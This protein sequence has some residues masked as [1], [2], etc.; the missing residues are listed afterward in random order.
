MRED[1]NEEDREEKQEGRRQFRRDFDLLL[2][3]SVEQA[4]AEL[5]RN[6]DTRDVERAADR[7]RVDAEP[8]Q[9][10]PTVTISETTFTPRETTGDPVPVGLP[11][12]AGS[13]VP[14][15]DLHTINYVVIGGVLV[16]EFQV[17][18]KILP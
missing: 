2:R 1:N 14:E 16:Y 11:P 13:S 9:P 4:Q 3:T 7:R 5:R 12:S 8:P 15:G 6:Q 10:P 17:R 18:G